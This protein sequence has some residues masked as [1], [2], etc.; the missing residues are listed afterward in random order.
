MIIMIM[1]MTIDNDHDNDND[2][3][4]RVNIINGPPPQE[5]RHVCGK[6]YFLRWLSDF[7]WEHKSFRLISSLGLVDCP[8]Q[9]V[10]IWIVNIQ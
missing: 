1:T 7:R 3:D 10:S 5:K 9:L 2:H 8:T 4:D 6:S